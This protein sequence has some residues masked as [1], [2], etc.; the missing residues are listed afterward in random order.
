MTNL[1]I[2]E[3][4]T[5]NPANQEG[6]GLAKL[7]N[8][9]IQRFPGAYPLGALESGR[10]PFAVPYLA[11]DFHYV[12]ATGSSSEE[13]CQ[14]VDEAL[15]EN[16]QAILHGQPFVRDIQSQQSTATSTCRVITEI[17]QALLVP[18]NTK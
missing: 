12:L 13:L 18:K 6:G 5:L 11:S 9:L 16:P 7:M 14:C 10:V 8:D 15:R 2:K 4:I 3:I 1:P 17:C